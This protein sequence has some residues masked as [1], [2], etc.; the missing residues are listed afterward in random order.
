M[1]PSTYSVYHMHAAVRQAFATNCIIRMSYAKHLRSQNLTWCLTL[2]NVKL[3]ELTVNSMR[4]V[5]RFTSG[6]LSLIM[7][8]SSNI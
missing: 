4:H 5:A 7:L 6:A 2:I 3:Y 8:L 1:R